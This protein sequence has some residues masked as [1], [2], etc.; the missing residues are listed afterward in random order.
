M[1]GFWKLT[2]IEAK[3]FFRIP[4]M[5]FFTLALPLIFLFLFGS[6]YGNAPSPLYG[7]YGSVDISVPAYTAM[8]IGTSALLSLTITLA[9]YRERG[10]LRRFRVTPVSPAAVLGAQLVVLFVM[11]LAGMGLLVLAGKIVY[12]MRFE[13]N[14]F[15]VLAAF[16]LSCLSFFA[17]GLVLA[18][19]MPNARVANMVGLVLL[20]PMI[21]LSG[22]TIPMEV[23]TPAIRTVSKFIPMTYVVTLL[24]GLWKGDSWSLHGTEVIVLSA[25]LV[26]SAVV[27]VKVFRWE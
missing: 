7:G 2:W 4:I 13:G 3:L 20:Y 10:I 26:V 5:A 9:T 27:A 16:T 11:T 18:S 24:Q 1:R 15:S 22:A 23:M 12:G 21:F 14:A 17:F 8:I 19:L 6:I 25:I